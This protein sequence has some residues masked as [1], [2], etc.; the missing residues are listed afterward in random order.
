MKIVVAIRQVPE[1]GARLRINAAGNALEEDGLQFATNEP[2]AYALEHA[3]ALRAVDGGEVIAVS[4]GLERA[5]NGLRDA[6]ARGAD[7]AVH[8]VA[9]SLDALAVAR[10]L[11]AVVQAEKADLLLAGLQS[12]DMGYGQ[13]PVLAAG[14][15]GVPHTTLALAIAKSDRGLTVTRELEEG[16]R[17]RVELPLPS[18]VAVQAGGIALS[19]A[20]LMGIKR[21]RTKELRTVRAAELGVA[22]VSTLVM[23]RLELPT[24]AKATQRIEGSPDQA[25]AVLIEKLRNEVKVL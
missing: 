13:T 22:I 25:A 3:L 11:A 4:V 10:V 18:V 1:R 14:L 21:A 6:L 9:E 12:E 19:Y 5:A 20:T 16:W 17:Q 15:L 7:R 2:D 24:R 8:V 23:E